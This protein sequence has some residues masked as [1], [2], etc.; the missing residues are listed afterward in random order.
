MGCITGEVQVAYNYINTCITCRSI[1]IVVPLGPPGACD[2]NGQVY[3]LLVCIF[4]KICYKLI[5]T[6]T[7][8]DN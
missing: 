5:Q 1:D 6:T 7:A 2:S 4:S 8:N 3:N